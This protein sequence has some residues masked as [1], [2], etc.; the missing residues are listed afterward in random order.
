MALNGG[1]GSLAKRIELRFP[2]P[3]IPVRFR[4]GPPFLQ[5]Q[6][7]HYSEPDP[8]TGTALAPSEDRM[9][10]GRNPFRGRMWAAMNCSPASLIVIA[11]HPRLGLGGGKYLWGDSCGRW[12]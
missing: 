10:S 6:F 4:T 1:G 3:A 11:P 12:S 2:K 8:G 5:S 9:G 7:L